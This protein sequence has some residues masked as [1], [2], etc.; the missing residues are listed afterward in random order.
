LPP[1]ASKD[2]FKDGP[3]KFTLCFTGEGFEAFSAA[4]SWC[5]RNGYSYGS[6]QRD[7]PIG[8]L[9]GD[10]AI[11]KWRN[12]SMA[13]RAGLDGT[14]E[15]DKRNGPVYVHLREDVSAEGGAA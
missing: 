4:T 10:Y 5:R 3:P 13:E 14:I 9:K 15:G 1:P 12:L 2:V 7:D 8:L 6:T 11:A